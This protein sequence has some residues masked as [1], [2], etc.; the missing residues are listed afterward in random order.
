LVT[1]VSRTAAALR[2]ALWVMAESWL[3]RLV[4]LVAFLA[5]AWRRFFPR[6]APAAQN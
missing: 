1:A 6:P 3:V 4:S 2:S 5:L